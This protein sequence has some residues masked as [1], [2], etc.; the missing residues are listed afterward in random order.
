MVHPVPT[1][2][3]PPKNGYPISLKSSPRTYGGMPVLRSVCGPISMFAP[4][5][6]G[7]AHPSGETSPQFTPSSP[8][9]YRGI[10]ELITAFF[11]PIQVRPVQV[12]SKRP[13]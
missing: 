9:T 10:P 7:Y 8:R 5:L 13:L 11:E 4:Y 1:G 3:F 12:G 6:R 2:V